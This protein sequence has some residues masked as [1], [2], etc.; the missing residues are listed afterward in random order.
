MLQWA[1]RTPAGLPVTSVRF[2]QGEKGPAGELGPRGGCGTLV[3]PESHARSRSDEPRTHGA[4]GTDSHSALAPRE[5]PRTGLHP[6]TDSREENKP[7]PGL[8]ALMAQ[9]RKQT[10]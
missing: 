6:G 1:L 10:T 7:D 3:Q 4:G 9:Q 2:T 8:T 5:P